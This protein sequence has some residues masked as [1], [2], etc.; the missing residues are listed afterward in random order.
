MQAVILAGG[1]GSRLGPI[2]RE[3]PKP[4]VPIAGAPYLDH[5]L[6]LLRRQH[7]SDILLLTGYLGDQIESYFGSGD[8]RGLSIRYSHERYPLGTGG[9]LLQAANMLEEAFVLIYGDSFLPIAYA[10]TLSELEKTGASGVVVV[11]DNRVIET[12]VPANIA[13]DSQGFVVRYEKDTAGHPELSFVDAGVLALRRDVI[14]LIP[15]GPVSLEKQVFPK[16]IE[17]RKLV[18]Y[19]TSQR[20]YDIGTPERLRLIESFF[21]HDYYSHSIS[22]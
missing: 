17:R 13:V 20:F 16:L 1:L 10:E 7:I 12:G 4:M 19:I 15:Q 5:Q 6:K 22:N 14:D 3:I 18:S 9:A 21:L 11:C 8:G 2:T